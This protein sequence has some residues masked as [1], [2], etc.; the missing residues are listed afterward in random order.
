MKISK[1]RLESFSDGV[2]AI[3]ITIMVL[4]IPIPDNLESKNIITFLNSLLT[5]FISFFLV[6]SFWNQHRYLFN[7]IKNISEQIIWRNMLFL[8]FLSLVPVFTKWIMNDPDISAP[9]VGYGVLLLSLSLSFDFMFSAIIKTNI[10]IMDIRT[11]DRKLKMRDL[12]ILIY[13]RSLVLSIGVIIVILIAIPYPAISAILFIGF[14]IIS[15][16][17]N[18]WFEDKNRRNNREE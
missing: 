14:P 8:F 7:E 11:I 18:L 2:M 10:D 12:K 13:F 5:Y 16:L 9:V 1:N 4:S 6:G 17:F 3:V 15:S